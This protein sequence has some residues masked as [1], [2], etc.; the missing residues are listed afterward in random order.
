MRLVTFSR[1]GGPPRLGALLPRDPGQL[2]DL[3]QADG[4]RAAASSGAFASMQALIEAGPRAWDLAR[5]VLEAAPDEGVIAAADVGL[6]APLPRPVR[7]R[8]FSVFESHAALSGKISL[9]D[10]WYE[11]PVYY[12]CNVFSVVGPDSTVAWPAGSTDIDYELEFAAVIG[13]GGKGVTRANALDHLFGYTIFNDL[14]ARDWQLKEMKAGLGPGRGKDFDGSNVLGPCIV[15]ADEIPDP[16]DLTMT[17]TIN[18]EEWSRGSSSTMRHR[19]EDMIEF[20]SENETLVPG[21]IFGSGTVGG[22]CGLELD[23]LLRRGDEVELTI[24]HLGSLRTRIV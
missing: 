13:R 20:V 15:T 12:K 22:G 9:A 2:L 6:L 23:R 4:A 14:S 11:W 1:A 16:Y 21:E 19:F 24:E 10:V 3:Q 5:V 18:G 8:D 17:A 7:M